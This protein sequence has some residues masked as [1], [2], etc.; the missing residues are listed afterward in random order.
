MKVTRQVTI[1]KENTKLSKNLK[2]ITDH[3]LNLQILVNK[4]FS[5]EMVDGVMSNE[6]ECGNVEG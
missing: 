2:L 4:S 1:K 6:A 3:F 5:V